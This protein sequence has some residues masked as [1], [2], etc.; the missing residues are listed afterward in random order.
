MFRFFLGLTLLLVVALSTATATADGERTVVV[1]ARRFNFQPD[2]IHVKK[3]ETVRLRL[4]S[5]DVPHSLQMKDLG[6]DE[7]ATRKQP[8]EAVF[9][10]RNSGVFHGKCGRFCGEGHGK[11]AFTISVDGN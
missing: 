1:H 9:T 2:T 6:I 5:D 7:T 4:I 11:M 10:A 8:G 3:G